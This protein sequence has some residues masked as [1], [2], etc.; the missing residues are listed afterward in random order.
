MDV[1]VYDE[2]V[3]FIGNFKGLSKNCSKKLEELFP[4]INSDT[5]YSILCNEY[6]RKMRRIYGKTQNNRDYFWKLFWEKIDREKP[7]MLVKIAEEHEIPP[8][9][10]AKLI[11]QKYYE[12]EADE[13]NLDKEP[14]T[15][16]YLYLKNTSLISDGQLAQEIFLCTVYDSLYSPLA[17]IMKK[18][19]GQQY[20]IRLQK[21]ATQRGLVFRDEESLR[22]YGYDKT[23]DL[24][25]EAPVAVDGFIV[26][27]VE[28]KALF[29]DEDIHKD[30]MKS[31]YLSYWNSFF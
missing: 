18:S 31:Q 11:L 14:A 26:N 5:L 15:K 21:E 24:K 2:I 8:C 9:L 30:Y 29:A 19:L 7:G 6:Q 20:E 1:S 4:S 3:S 16:L 27:W 13:E 10:I 17:D 25:L 28:S 23:P 12:G 22:K